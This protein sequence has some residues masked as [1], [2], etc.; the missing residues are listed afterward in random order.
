MWVGVRE[1]VGELRVPQN[2]TDL[3]NVTFKVSF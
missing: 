1:A 2:N 3:E